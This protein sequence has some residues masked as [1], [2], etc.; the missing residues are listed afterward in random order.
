MNKVKHL[1]KWWSDS[2]IDIV[3][4]EGKAI[5]LYGWNGEVYM[6]CWEV[7]DIK[8]NIGFES[9]KETYIAKP[10]YDSDCNIIEYTLSQI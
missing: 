3:E 4:I 6:E 5:A 10:I 1:G 8:Q 9:G 7:F 2:T